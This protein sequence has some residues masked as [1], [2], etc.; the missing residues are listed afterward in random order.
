HPLD[1]AGVAVLVS[2]GRRVAGVWRPAVLGAAVGIAV[3]TVGH[4]LFT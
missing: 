3:R 4:A 1:L 2:A